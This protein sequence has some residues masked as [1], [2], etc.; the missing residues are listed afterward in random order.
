M[1]RKIRDLKKTF[2]QLQILREVLNLTTFHHI[3]IRIIM[4]VN[5]LFECYNNA[6]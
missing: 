1:E 3:I 6:C 2:V 4:N 5:E